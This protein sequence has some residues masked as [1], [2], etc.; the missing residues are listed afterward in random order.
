[1]IFHGFRRRGKTANGATQPGQPWGIPWGVPPRGIPQGN[2]PGGSPKGEP[3]GGPPG[4]SPRGIPLGDPPN[5]SPG[6][7]PWGPTGPTVQGSDFLLSS[8]SWLRW[9]EVCVWGGG[10]E[11]SP[12][13]RRGDRQSQQCQFNDFPRFSMTFID[14]HEISMIFI[15]F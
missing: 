1:M 8:L 9:G 11:L 4:R 5:E 15:D 3:P 13:W 7:S 2:S 14:L 10:P 12:R 6:G